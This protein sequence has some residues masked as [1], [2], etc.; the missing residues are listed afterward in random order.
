GCEI[1]YRLAE[2]AGTERD[3][4]LLPGITNYR[5]GDGRTV[6]RDGIIGEVKVARRLRQQRR[7]DYAFICSIPR[8]YRGREH[9]EI[10]EHSA[11]RRIRVVGKRILRAHRMVQPRGELERNARIPAANHE[12][13][14]V[15]RI[16]EHTFGNSACASLREAAVPSDR[17]HQLD[18]I[19]GD[20]DLEIRRELSWHDAACGRDLRRRGHLD[21]ECIDHCMSELRFV[22]VAAVELERETNV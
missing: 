12:A 18:R 19:T 15:F 5:D 9:V 6:E 13:C 11:A 4:E 14:N 3:D 8:E 16:G 22:P 7:Q 2:G 1:V 21:L 10:A 17:V 20:R